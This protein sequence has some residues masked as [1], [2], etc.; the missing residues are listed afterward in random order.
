MNNT[1]K[2]EIM[3][4]SS[5]RNKYLNSTDEEESQKFVK[6]MNLCVSQKERQKRVINAFK[7]ICQ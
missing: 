4:S 1:F 5:L 3:K 6:Q 2:K 7:Q